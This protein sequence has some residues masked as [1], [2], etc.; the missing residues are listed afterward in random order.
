MSL[1]YYAA[2]DVDAM[3]GRQLAA[4]ARE[5]AEESLLIMGQDSSG[6]EFQTLAETLATRCKMDVSEMAFGISLAASSLNLLDVAMTRE[7]RSVRPLVP[8]QR[9]H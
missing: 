5:V 2:C 8:S 9:G 1:E 3:N 7:G 4:F 6:M